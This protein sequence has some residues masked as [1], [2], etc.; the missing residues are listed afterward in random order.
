MSH[1]NEVAASV[2]HVKMV[3][4]YWQTEQSESWRAD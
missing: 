1:F 2:K 3:M 4:N